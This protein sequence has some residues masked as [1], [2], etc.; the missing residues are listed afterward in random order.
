MSASS[1]QTHLQPDGLAYASVRAATAVVTAG[2]A[3]SLLFY[4]WR[5]TTGHPTVFDP[6]RPA[7]E[8]AVRWL[9]GSPKPEPASDVS[10]K[11]DQ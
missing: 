7:A 6:I 5:G 11:S 8:S 9:R 1:L 4:D 3:A 10:S 2:V